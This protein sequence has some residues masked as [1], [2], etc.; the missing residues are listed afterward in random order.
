MAPSG[1][2]PWQEHSA[3]SA[4]HLAR[5]CELRVRTFLCSSSLLQS[6]TIHGRCSGSRTGNTIAVSMANCAPCHS[7]SPACAHQTCCATPGRGR[8]QTRQWTPEPLPRDKLAAAHSSKNP[9]LPRTPAS[10]H[11][12]RW[13]PR[14]SSGRPHRQVR[15]H[16]RKGRRRRL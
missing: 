10:A 3:V 16:K 11:A 7:M 12:A 6:C 5:T 4:D 14:M 1:L 2:G 15:E 13:C 8:E 9:L